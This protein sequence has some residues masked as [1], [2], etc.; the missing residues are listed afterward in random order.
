MVFVEPVP[1]VRQPPEAPQGTPAKVSV[2][3]APT[4]TP[5]LA[6]PN[7]PTDTFATPLK[8]LRVAQLAS[9][10]GESGSP[11]LLNTSGDGMGGDGVM[12]GTPLKPASDVADD[13]ALD[14]R[15]TLSKVIMHELKAVEAG[16]ERDEHTKTLNSLRGKIRDWMAAFEAKE[17]RKPEKSDKRAIK[18]DFLA[19][20]EVEKRLEVTTTTDRVLCLLCRHAISPCRIPR[21][22]SKM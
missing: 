6:T 5:N 15:L 3:L 21:K 10:A 11:G 2:S 1:V 7:P 4:G 16:E 8:A 20:R 18:A 17:G 19:L 22:F 14:A 12:M 9:G 13:S